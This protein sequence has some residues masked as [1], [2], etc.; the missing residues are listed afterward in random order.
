MKKI[1][2]GLVAIALFAP[3]TS[4]AATLNG[5]ILLQVEE[6]GEAWY[7]NPTDGGRYFLG[8]PDDA[9]NLMRNLGLGIST[10]DLNQI[11]IGLMAQSGDDTDKDGLV[12]LLEQAI[13]TN[14]TKT[15]T[16][17]DGFLDKTELLN[18]YDPSGANRFP[19]LPLNQN[20]ID[21]LK[22]RILL[23]VENKG[24]AWYVTPDNGKRYF[25][26]RPIHAFEIMRG[27]GL[28]VK[29]SVLEGIPVKILMTKYSQANR[30]TIKY[31][32]SWSVA[33]P[34]ITAGEKVKKAAIKS[35][36]VFS[37]EKTKITV[38]RL[39]SASALGLNDFSYP[40]AKYVEKISTSNALIENHASLRQKFIYR[41]EPSGLKLEIVTTIMVNSKN[42]YQINLVSSASDLAADE[43]L[44][45]EMIASFKLVS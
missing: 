40:S 20:L 43:K 23:Q 3:L 18:G 24:E 6:H 28:G 25:L 7:V 10:K 14:I 37:G 38:L 17:N 16:D 30:F 32:Q 21:R 12:D 8:R 13:G 41:E 35:R 34:T 27:L 39:E 2:F 5:K 29:N 19:A 1:I 44:Y 31:P 42:F 22:G 9:Y 45:N 26:G 11:P 33:E 4:Q 36:T 15:D